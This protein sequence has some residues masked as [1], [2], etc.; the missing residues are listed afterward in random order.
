MATDAMRESSYNTQLDYDGLSIKSAEN[1]FVESDNLIEDMKEAQKEYDQNTQEVA[2]HTTENFGEMSKSIQTTT[3][4]SEKLKGES[5]KLAN[6][7]N[8]ELIPA[9]GNAK[10][11]WEDYA[12][13]LREVIKLTD[14][15][16][17]NAD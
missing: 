10:L 16:M 3:E 6:N 9:I 17:A 12:N 1:W 2:Q 8:E 14:E 4:K 15:A 5:K 11:A 7:L 13:F